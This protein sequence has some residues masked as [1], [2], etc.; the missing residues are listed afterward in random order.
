MRGSMGSVIRTRSGA[1]R[2]SC[3][4]CL[5]GI[6][7]IALL[8]VLPPVRAAEESAARLFAAHAIALR[9]AAVAGEERAA[10][11]LAAMPGAGMVARE[12]LPAVWSPFFANAIIKL[13]RLRSSGPVALYYDPL[14][15]I[16]VFTLWARGDEGYHVVSI[17]AL[18]GER[19]AASKV[20]VDIEPSWV[21]AKQGAVGALAR[22]TAARLDAFRW[23]HPPDA[24][25][26]G[27]DAATFAAA[28]ADFR[29][30]LPRLAWNAAQRTR[31]TDEA[32]AWL[33]PALAE[34][35]KALAARDPAALKIAAPDTDAETAATL[36]A[37]PTGFA[38]NLALDM[39]LEGGEADR[40]LVGSLVADGDIYVLAL[41]RI[42]GGAC[43][44]RRFVL[45]SLLE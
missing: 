45:V 20:A 29:A 41:C 3:A 23:S 26:P 44:L 19:I 5:V 1:I 18:P 33:R 31:W 10:E 7:A 14:L 42:E 25:E 27:R 8:L 39:V 43:G 30:A 22:T 35:E 21:S 34:V 9:S 11:V 37:L 6:L 17:R 36:A 24:R 40:L 4:S 32:Q 12:T 16:A 38:A 2:V 13:G 15:D 28:A